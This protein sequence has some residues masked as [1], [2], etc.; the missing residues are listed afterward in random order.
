MADGD[1]RARF[2][3]FKVTNR[4]PRHSDHR[5]IVVETEW[6]GVDLSA[7]RSNPPFR[8]EAG[9]V[10]EEKCGVIVDNA[11]KLSMEAR[12]SNF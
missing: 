5:P 4:D 12:S 7:R 1:W 9:W 3:A 2:P 10:D 11:W 6:E 8:F